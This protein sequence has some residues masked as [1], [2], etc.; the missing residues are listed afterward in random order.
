MRPACPTWNPSLR[1]GK[2][3]LRTAT[4]RTKPTT[5][6]RMLR[7]AGVTKGCTTG[8][9][10]VRT[11]TER[12]TTPTTTVYR[13]GPLRNLC[14]GPRWPGAPAKG[15]PLLLLLN[16]HLRNLTLGALP[17]RRYDQGL[18]TGLIDWSVPTPKMK[19]GTALQTHLLLIITQHATRMY[20]DRLARYFVLPRTGAHKLR[21]ASS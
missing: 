5:S 14:R 1:I 15:P 17:T 18:D 7:S 6:G 8:H 11:I 4:P 9:C 19:I 2:P 3:N 10:T 20:A 21:P 12:V 16:Q 13:C